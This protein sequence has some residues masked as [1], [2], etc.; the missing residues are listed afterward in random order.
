MIKLSSD[1]IR[2]LKLKLMRSIRNGQFKLGK[3]R[4]SGKRTREIWNAILAV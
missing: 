2:E 1:Q 3:L 4:A